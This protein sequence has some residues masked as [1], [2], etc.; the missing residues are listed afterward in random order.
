MEDRLKVLIS[1]CACAPNRGSEP[2]VGWQWAMQMSRFHDVTVLTRA[3]NRAVIEQELLQHPGTSPRPEF[4]YHEEGPLLLWLRNRFGAVRLYYHF[5]QRSAWKVV[6]DLHKT[7]RFDLMHHS[8]FAGFRFRT[9][10]WNHSCPTVWGPVGGIFAL[11][12]R[13]QPWNNLPALAFEATRHLNNLIQW[14]PFHALPRRYSLSTVTLAS[15]LEMQELFKELNLTVPLMPAIGIGTTKVPVTDRPLATGPLKILFVGNVITLKGIDMALDAFAE[16]KINAS[17]TIVGDGRFMGLALKRVRNLGIADKVIFL[18]RLAS[19][20]TLSSYK[21]FDV[22][23]FPSL[24]DTG[25]FAVLEAMSGGMPVICLDCGG[26]RLSVREGAGIKVPLGHRKAL[27]SGLANALRTYDSDRELLAQHGRTARQL[28]RENY[29]WDK[30][31]EQMNQVYHQALRLASQKNV[32]RDEWKIY[33]WKGFIRPIFAKSLMVSSVFMLMVGLVGFF[34]V[35]KL[36][37]YS[38][39]I[40]DDTLPS[41]SQAGLVNSSLAEAYNRTLLACMSDTP[42]EAAR[43]QFEIDEF[44][45]RSESILKLYEHYLFAAEE[46]SIYKD[47]ILKRQIYLELRDRVIGLVMSSRKAEAVALC[48]SSLHP[49]Y[50]NYKKSAQSLMLFDIHQGSARGNSII[51]ACRNTQITVIAIGIFLFVAG[52]LLGFFK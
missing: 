50:L 4:V 1:A 13:L 35:Q 8:T 25:G 36:S 14:A 32:G 15:T 21:E 7:R 27:V 16:S 37:R 18:G 51:N 44:S 38:A 52:F 26:P 42:A 28:V 48:K 33:S 11:D 40:V 12:W 46:S 19:E 49:A 23:L 34:S 31:G 47:V 9:A 45:Q 22:F 10:I 41:L 39:E 30:K 3:A 24:H 20:E 29:D 6:D 43:Y 2:E 5:W 17:F